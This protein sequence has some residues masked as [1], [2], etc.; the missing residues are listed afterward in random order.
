MNMLHSIILPQNIFIHS[1]AN[2]LH[3]EQEKKTK[4]WNKKG[5]LFSKDGCEEQNSPQRQAGQMEFHLLAMDP[6]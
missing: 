3:L 5:R 6:Y 4:I 1:N 2:L